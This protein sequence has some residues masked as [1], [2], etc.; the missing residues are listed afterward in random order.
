MAFF[1]VFPL[2]VQTALIRFLDQIEAR[3]ISAMFSN[4]GLVKW[5]QEIEDHIDR[6]EFVIG[7][8]KKLPYL[9]S[10]ISSGNTLTLTVTSAPSGSN[11]AQKLQAQIAESIAVD[12]SFFNE[13]CAIYW[14]IIYCAAFFNISFGE[15]ASF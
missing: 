1:R 14:I 8:G 5:P 10:C 7:R 13:W 4:I 15:H 9:F 12:E 3:K 6:L 2:A 11:I